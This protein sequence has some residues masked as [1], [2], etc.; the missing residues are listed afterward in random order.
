M[1][2]S[3]VLHRYLPLL[4]CTGLIVFVALL[5][6]PDF[7]M[8]GGTDHAGHLIYGKLIASGQ[9]PYIDFWLHKTP[10]YSFFLGLW[11]LVFGS[12]WW[13]AK[14][15]L[16]ITYGLFA[17]SIYAFC[18]VV[19]RRR[20]LPIVAAAAGTYLS[21]RLGFDPARNGSVLI[22]AISLELFAL[23]SLFRGIIGSQRIPYLFLIAGV[24]ASSAFLAR[25]GSITPFVI[26]VAAPF[27][28]A[29]Q[30]RDSTLLK[31]ITRIL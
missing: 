30:D 10:L 14:G 19:F 9:L 26:A 28:F 13:S 22:F 17:I 8:Y 20:W 11:Q 27:F 5:L 24:L 1:S 4:E 25:Q 31:R 16:I 29:Y 12:S 21:L 3:S 23:T 15:S 2:N 7:W 18:V 6:L